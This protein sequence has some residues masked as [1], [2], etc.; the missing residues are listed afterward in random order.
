VDQDILVEEY[1]A[2]IYASFNF[3]PKSSNAERICLWPLKKPAIP[4]DYVGHSILCCSVEFC[5]L[6]DIA[7][8]IYYKHTFG[9]ENNRIIRPRWIC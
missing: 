7:K 6:L 1:L 8:D 4:A 3:L 5:D 9:G 2:V